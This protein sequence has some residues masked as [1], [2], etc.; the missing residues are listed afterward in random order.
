MDAIKIFVSST[1]KDLLPERSAVEK[2]LHRFK[3]TRF[4]GME[5]FGTSDRSTTDVSLDEVDKS[6]I[7]LGVI[8]HR[9]GS[10]ITEQEYRRA[11]QR[12]LPCLIYL[13]A[14]T[15]AE[16]ANSSDDLKRCEKLRAELLRQHTVSFFTTPEEL[17]VKVMADLHNA[18]FDRL[19]VQGIGLLR[20]DYDARIRRFVSEYLGDSKK[21]IPFGGREREL[22]R[23]DQWLRRPDGVPYALLGGPA[24]RGKSALLV[25]WA[26]QVSDRNDVAVIFFPVSVRFRTNVASVV[27]SSIAARL[28][29]L[30][31]EP[32]PGGIDTPPEVWRALMSGYLARNLPN[33]RRLLVILDGADE[34]GDWQVDQL[35]FPAQPPPGL[36]V[37]ISARYLAGDVGAG[38][39]LERLGWFQNGLAETLDLAPLDPQ[40]LVE[41]LRRMGVPFEVLSARS[42][43]VAELFRLTQGDP[44][45][46]N[47]YVADLW[48]HRDDIARLKPADLTSLAPGIEGYFKR[49][50]ED[51]RR[52]WGGQSPEREPE[53]GAVL[54]I[55][56]CALGPLLSDELLALLPP[57]RGIGASTLKG[58]VHILQRFIIGDGR[59]QGYTFSHPRLAEYFYDGLAKDKQAQH[60]EAR[61][62]SWGL[63]CLK[64]LQL[65]SHSPNQ[66]PNYI[67]RFMRRHM[68]RCDSDPASFLV[69]ASNSWNAAWERLDRGSYSGFLRDLVR[70][71]DIA[72]QQNKANARAGKTSD[73]VAAEL[74]CALSMSSIA[75]LA[76]DMSVSVILAL[77]RKEIWSPAQA[78]A[79]AAN[80]TV[81]T[82]R[83]SVLLELAG[84]IEGAHRPLAIAAV[85]AEARR[86]MMTSEG[87]LVFEQVISSLMSVDPGSIS[88]NEM[89]QVTDAICGVASQLDPF[90]HEWFLRELDIKQPRQPLERYATAR[91]ALASHLSEPQKSIAR[92]EALYAI[93][94]IAQSSKGP[95]TAFA[96]NRLLL[97][98]HAISQDRS[99]V[100]D[101]MVITALRTAI[102]V[103][104]LLARDPTEAQANLIDAALICLEC[105]PM[106]DR[107]WAVERLAPH[108]A[109]N[110]V[111][112]VI[113]NWPADDEPDTRLAALV[114]CL[115]AGGS[116][117]RSQLKDALMSHLESGLCTTA[118]L[119]NQLGVAVRTLGEA[120]ALDCLQLACSK[121]APEN[122]LN[123]C[124]RVA[125]ETP[126]ST[127]HANLCKRVLE[128]VRR[129]MTQSLLLDAV[130]GLSDY[131]T[132]ASAQ[133][134]FDAWRPLPE[135]RS[136]ALPIFRLFSGAAYPIDEV[137]D[138]LTFLIE[139][140]YLPRGASDRLRSLIHLK[141]DLKPAAKEADA[142]ALKL[143]ESLLSIVNELLS[144]TDKLSEAI[145]NF[146][147][148]AGIGPVLT[149]LAQVAPRLSRNAQQL[150]AREIVDGVDATRIA[151][152]E[153][154]ALIAAVAAPQLFPP[155]PDLVAATV[156]LVQ[157]ACL[158][159]ETYGVAFDRAF[160]RIPI[161][162]ILRQE[163]LLTRLKTVSEKSN[164]GSYDHLLNLLM[165]VGMLSCPKDE[166]LGLAMATLG[167]VDA[168]SATF[169]ILNRFMPLLT[170]SVLPRFL[171]CF[172]KMGIDE[173][174]GILR[175]LKDRRCKHLVIH[176]R[177]VV[178]AVGHLP[179]ARQRAVWIFSIAPLICE[180]A[181]FDTSLLLADVED[182]TDRLLLLCALIPMSAHT[183]HRRLLVEAL[184]LAPRTRVPASFGRTLVQ[185]A[186]D[187]FPG[188]SAVM[189]Q[190]VTTAVS[191]SDPELR[192]A[193]LAVL[194]EGLTADAMID[195]AA[196]LRRLNDA[197]ARVRAM[198]A[199]A[200]L[201]IDLPRRSKTVDRIWASI[202]SLRGV[203]KAAATL[204]AAQA[205]PEAVK[206]T[207]MVSSF[208]QLGRESGNFE[209]RELL[210]AVS[211]ALIDSPA[212]LY[213]CAI[214][215]MQKLP[216]DQYR[217][218]TLLTLFPRL[219]VWLQV[220]ALGM[221]AQSLDS[222]EGLR[223]I[224][225]YVT[226]SILEEFEESLS[227]SL[228]RFSPGTTRILY[229]LIK[230][231]EEARLPSV[232][233]PVSLQDSDQRITR[234]LTSGGEVKRASIIEF[235]A[236][237]PQLG[238]MWRT[239]LIGATAQIQ[240]DRL[241]PSVAR[242]L[243]VLSD[244]ELLDLAISAT[245]GID[246]P[247]DRAA[248]T[249][250]LALRHAGQTR[251]RLLDEAFGDIRAEPDDFSRAQ[252]AIYLAKSAPERLLDC[253]KI[254]P[255]IAQSTD[256]EETI[257]RIIRELI[258]ELQDQ[259]GALVVK[260]LQEF[261]DE[262]LRAHIILEL[263][264]NFG[265]SA[266]AA[267]LEIV[268]GLSSQIARSRVLS[269]LVPRLLPTHLPDCV[270]ILEKTGTDFA[271]L[272]LL[273]AMTL[274]S[275]NCLTAE[276]ALKASKMLTEIDDEEFVATW[277]T[278][279]AFA[280]PKTHQDFLI[281]S[282]QRL[283]DPMWCREALSAIA[284]HCKY[285]PQSTLA[286]EMRKINDTFHRSVALGQLAS[287][288]E[289]LNGELLREAMLMATRAGTRQRY[290]DALVLMASSAE[291]VAD[292]ILESLADRCTQSPLLVITAFTTICGWMTPSQAARLVERIAEWS[293]G[294]YA[295]DCA[296]LFRALA[297]RLEPGK[298]PL[299]MRQAR[300]LCGEQLV[301][302]FLCDLAPLLADGESAMAAFNIAAEMHSET[303][304]VESLTGL[305]I[306]FDEELQTRVV[307]T[308]ANANSEH[309][310]YRRLIGIV[311]DLKPIARQRLLDEAQR[312][313][314]L[315]YTERLV[316]AICRA[317]QGERTTTDAPFPPQ[318]S[319]ADAQVEK[320]LRSLLKEAARKRRTQE[321]API[322]DTEDTIGYVGGATV[323]LAKLHKKLPWDRFDDVLRCLARLSRSEAE[324]LIAH[325]PDLLP[326]NRLAE[327]L[328]AALEL[329][330]PPDFGSILNAIRH[331][332]DD[333]I[334]RILDRIAAIKE[335]NIMA[336]IDEYLH[337]EFTDGAR[338]ERKHFLQ[339][340]RLLTPLIR[341]FGGDV[342]LT[343]TVEA[344]ADV[345][346]L[347]P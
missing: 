5:Y 61:F 205:L 208:E 312:F 118:A 139:H 18:I 291:V 254:L 142:V 58:I 42:D 147:N 48:T 330:P 52:L 341:R 249:I 301:S 165:D 79:Y 140:N 331:L 327:A 65:G 307:S 26:R 218:E 251:T 14:G 45:L 223:R 328:L 83:I 329:S 183:A 207:A 153:L 325:L 237:H 70:V 169:R 176:W 99:L 276:R 72:A 170:P 246:S 270:S 213:Q 298:L 229:A 316:Q 161:P 269:S 227:G 248:A 192:C 84:R 91:L 135:Q 220:P 297:E 103:A 309:E 338:L 279:V 129:P 114:T 308:L 216:A 305:L 296:E 4:G 44:L 323:A 128:S 275:D 210:E 162:D 235:M 299:L 333:D 172:N 320:M 191:L 134:S 40:G 177:E 156:G 95:P 188:D 340:I 59:A 310:R 66:V 160:K 283:N 149:A 306:S 342:A 102:E 175:Q 347:W 319:E 272:E 130:V 196:E 87:R 24:G 242:Y 117:V 271:W 211:H 6:D 120:E 344:I 20:S 73:F 255:T 240:N 101:E 75:S 124:C 150:V 8:G 116:Q 123:L 293:V 245:R 324:V 262:R 267:A 226:Q 332:D 201:I 98:R 209:R 202:Q 92:I 141:P 15:S 315:Q 41:V 46:V 53:V 185:I 43:V 236:L 32:V 203:T 93:Q 260:F 304:R 215:W 104:G 125:L 294:A 158:Q 96:G 214:L 194:A 35:L 266:A 10:G 74:R 290:I 2:A 68:E 110:H 187:R 71:R 252:A 261:E 288:S 126:S 231:R 34:A 38:G 244:N 51:Q 36:R 259:H 317:E 257:V 225:I 180:D 33:G 3:T 253:L 137:I 234:L 286:S 85:L 122:V 311:P 151:V 300:R 282:I 284:L 67:L 346:T 233:E 232:Q 295:A 62:I 155:G 339:R 186:A 13:K 168:S 154:C 212:R 16:K 241:R 164:S 144:Q 152:D 243:S 228:S 343:E 7:Y 12:G 106:E 100:T 69:L 273:A 30:H 19:V 60:L 250:M 326:E 321:K 258:G 90:D 302:A 182:E 49:W 31:G 277:I 263:A 224:A 198:C 81:E 131:A 278:K 199:F 303:S 335:D 132:L 136:L 289:P 292:S 189:K 256:D 287:V 97:L 37:L 88:I 280:W 313:K 107:L 264:P 239:Q 78:I 111:S 54:D 166:L 204:Y 39:W 29:A 80:I 23:L 222:D 217:T 221:I 1:W 190:A 206:W 265:P 178:E 157:T 28:A 163:F 9:Y 115:M 148:S 145:I 121:L 76:G 171:G 146:T 17:A 22:A 63:N 64:S 167:Q 268:R 179:N 247:A 127:V 47:L 184:N 77:I 113:G 27:Y 174:R 86:L 105:L 89:A 230:L 138:T 82:R 336:E 219:P 322:T 181:T 11:L 109:P 285:L 56:S 55:L 281:Q 197:P 193:A 108:F 133:D 25:H 334:L 57:E 337:Q 21:P 143:G 119:I 318:P 159:S 195:A 50:W 238:P 200:Q 173:R 345:G 314:Q 112:R 274:K 94:E